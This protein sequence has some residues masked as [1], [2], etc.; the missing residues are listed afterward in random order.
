MFDYVQVA[1]VR[2][3]QC[4]HCFSLTYSQ[5]SLESIHLSFNYIARYAL[6]KKSKNILKDKIINH[7]QSNL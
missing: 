4:K 3:N 2:N 7:S 6:F 1:I 5:L